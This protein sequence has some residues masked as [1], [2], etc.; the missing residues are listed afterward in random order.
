[1]REQILTIKPNLIQKIGG[2]VILPLKE[3]EK[4]QKRAAEAFSLKG[5]KA[6]ELDC[7]IRD[8]EIEYRT[9]KCKTIKSL[10]DLD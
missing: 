7:L 2:M 3:Y 10:A 6:K 4:L 9:G 5:K 1:M 8:G